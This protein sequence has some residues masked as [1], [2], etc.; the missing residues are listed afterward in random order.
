MEEKKAFEMILNSIWNS[1]IVIKSIDVIQM[2]LKC[3]LQIHSLVSSIYI[4]SAKQERHFKCFSNDFCSYV[5]IK[6]LVLYFKWVSHVSCKKL[7]AF[8]RPNMWIPWVEFTGNKL[9][10]S[11][12]LI[13]GLSIAQMILVSE[14]ITFDTG[15]PQ[16]WDCQI[17]K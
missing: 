8:I 12:V 14:W 5:T 10:G 7:K 17:S 3:N 16:T 2:D 15:F 4:T 6:S 11:S 1:C 13:F 9:L